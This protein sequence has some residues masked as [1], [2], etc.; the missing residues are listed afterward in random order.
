MAKG[1]V[2]VSATYNDLLDHRAAVSKALT[3]MG[4]EVHCME[5][6]VATDERVDDNC[7]KDVAECNFYVGILAQRYGWVPK[8]QEYSITELEYRQAR[9][10]I[11]TRCLI[12]ILDRDASWPQRW[13][14]AIHDGVAAAKLKAF[15]DEFSETAT[16]T[17]TSVDDLVREVMAAVH[18]EDAKAWK[19]ELQAEFDI[20]LVNSRVQPT[21]TS[22]NLLYIVDAE[23]SLDPSLLD[24]VQAAIASAGAA[25][26]ITIDLGY[27]GGWWSTRL[28]LLIG[29]LAEFTKV[30]CFVF[31]DSGEYIGTC[32]LHDTRR[33]LSVHFTPIATA[34]AKALPERRAFDP[35]ED[36]PQIV[37]RFLQQLEELGGEEKLRSQVAPHVVKRFH[38]FN[39]EIVNLVPIR[40]HVQRQWA[41]LAKP[42]QYV[43]IKEA[44]SEVSIVDRLV[45]ASR[46][47]ERTL[48]RL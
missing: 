23:T 40:D 9:K 15:R 8:N 47:A 48:A 16:A 22:N 34:F 31:Y 17:F 29:L 32:A 46:V 39:Q 25:Q 4:Y 21:E 12:F 36:V 18:I 43:A 20:C 3:K 10:Q 38:G 11:Y 6:Y 24:V 14:D 37:D 19:L 27:S 5:N 45:F 26:L 33:E 42:Y 7:A 13:I 41:V 30:N 2:Y 1:K 44:D 28:L 35:I